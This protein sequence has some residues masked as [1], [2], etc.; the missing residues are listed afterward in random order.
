M[1]K[2][3]KSWRIPALIGFA[4]MF[5]ILSLVPVPAAGSQMIDDS[6][7]TPINMAPGI[8]VMSPVSDNT[9][10]HLRV[11]ATFMVTGNLPTGMILA[12]A[13]LPS[14]EHV[15]LREFPAEA[16]FVRYSYAQPGPYPKAL[17]ENSCSPTSYPLTGFDLPVASLPVG[18]TVEVSV[19]PVRLTSGP[20][21]QF[22]KPEAIGRLVN[23]AQRN[24]V[25]NPNKPWRNRMELLTAELGARLPALY[26][27]EHNQ[28]LQQRPSSRLPHLNNLLIPNYDDGTVGRIGDRNRMPVVISFQVLIPCEPAKP[29]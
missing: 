18:A 22:M 5:P 6:T 3:R 26:S 27:Q 4:C 25:P 1:T 15:V 20:V 10:N 28:D 8:I 11:A 23:P 14:G 2:A 16:C 29:L 12:T 21:K 19:T 13:V 17:T 9:Q 24:G 7:G